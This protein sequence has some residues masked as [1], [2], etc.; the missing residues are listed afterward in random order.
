MTCQIYPS[1]IG[2]V[3]RKTRV[4][5]GAIKT[6]FTAHG[7]SVFVYGHDNVIF[8]LK[9]QSPTAALRRMLNGPRSLTPKL[10]NL[11]KNAG[12]CAP[13]GGNSLRLARSLYVV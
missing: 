3:S 11:P 5:A 6:D 4:D 10:T 7:T 1:P 2:S 12:R 13:N 8:C 9:F